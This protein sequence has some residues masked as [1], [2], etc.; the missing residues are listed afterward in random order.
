MDGVDCGV[1][2]EEGVDDAPGPPDP[3][4]PDD[5]DLVDD[6]VVDRGDADVDDF[7][8]KDDDGGPAPR[9]PSLDGRRTGLRIFSITV[10]SDPV[11]DPLP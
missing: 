9:M 7:S 1:C 2:L 5:P 10:M 6:E 4:A 3:D 11:S 8:D